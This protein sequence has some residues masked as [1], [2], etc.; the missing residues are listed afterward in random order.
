MLTKLTTQ[1]ESVSKA[2]G[3][4]STTYHTSLT[5]TFS[6]KRKEVNT[7]LSSAHYRGTNCSHVYVELSC[8]FKS[9]GNNQSV[10]NAVYKTNIN[11]SQSRLLCS[12]SPPSALQLDL[13]GSVHCS[14]EGLCL[15]LHPSPDEDS[16]V[17]F[18]II[19]SVIVGARPV[20]APSPLLPKDLP[21]DIPMDTW[22]P[23]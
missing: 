7:S 21:G 16:M 3:A 2:L 10:E 20:Q 22:D 1:M 18:E 14:D 6:L 17:I 15:Y 5:L 13:G 4:L 19:I 8:I 11:P 12:S 9:L 23:L